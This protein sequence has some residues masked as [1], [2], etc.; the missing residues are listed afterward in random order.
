MRRG[1]ARGPDLRAEL[2]IPAD[3]TVFGRHG[4]DNTFDIPEARSAVLAVARRRADIYFVLMNTR[5]IWVREGETRP[6]NILYLP[7]TTDERRKGDFIRSCDAMIH[8]RS[9]GETFGLAIAECARARRPMATGASRGRASRARVVGGARR[10]DRL[11]PELPLHR[12]PRVS[13]RSSP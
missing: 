5:E 2:G 3:A 4:G 7:P 6:P 10:R 11:S 1:A 8:A 9:S 13:P 12:P